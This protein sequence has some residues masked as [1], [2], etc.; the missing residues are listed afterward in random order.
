[1]AATD[2]EDY[3]DIADE[4]LIEAFSSQPSQTLPLLGSPRPSKRRRLREHPNSHRRGSRQSS[5]SNVSS[6]E[7]IEEEQ[8]KKSKYRIH[9]SEKEVWIFS[10]ALVLSLDFQSLNTGSS[11]MRA[12][13]E[14][15]ALRVRRF[16]LQGFSGQHKQMPYQTRAPTEF[17]VL[18]TRSPGQ[19]NQI[20]LPCSL[21]NTRLEVRQTIP[22]STEQRVYSCITIPSAMNSMTYPQMPSPPKN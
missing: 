21:H 15:V 14:R 10:V 6:G 5:A 1:M 9:I 4:D 13:I 2:E 16:Q 7:D 11:Q 12:F 19:S 18:Y 3:G 20:H 17:E 8:A 22:A